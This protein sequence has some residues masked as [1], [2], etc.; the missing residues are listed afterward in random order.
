MRAWQIQDRFSLESLR[1]VERAE[2]PPGPGQVAVRVR[3]VSLNHR[4]LLTVEGTYNPKQPLPLVPVSDGA[5]EV[6][7]VGPD[8]TRP[9]PGDRVAGLFAP[10]WIAGE[11]TR[12]RLRSTLGGPLD[13]MLAERVVLAAEGVAPFPEHLSFEEAACLPCAALTAWSAVAGP[14]GMTAGETLLVL[15]TGG[16]SLFALQLGRLL[17]A[18]VLVTSSSDA[19]LE[20]AR[21]LGAAGVVNYRTR[22]DWDEAVRERTGGRGVDRVVEVGGAGTLARSLRAVR[23]G[24]TVCLVGNL[25]GLEARLNLAHVFMRAVEL[26]GVLVG[27]REGFEAMS[28]AIALHEM[29]PVVDRVFAFD[30]APAAFRHL[31]SGAHFGKVVVR[32]G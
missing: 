23:T 2:E 7:A 12:E 15:G 24:G 29:R 26:R 32:V 28:R 3:A 30:D 9:R 19:K 17:G 13:G 31:E 20:R 27:S 10:R 14:R 8:V 6:E 22:P 16:V 1:L 18:R 25:S 4:D 5:G 21:E 11:P